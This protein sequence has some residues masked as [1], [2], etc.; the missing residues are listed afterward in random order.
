MYSYTS[1]GL[2]TKKRVQ[3]DGHNLDGTYTYN[4]EGRVATVQHP[5]AQND[6]GLTWTYSFDSMGRPYSLVDN[7][8][9]PYHMVTSA[10]YGPS[11]EELQINGLA[12]RTYNSLL[13]LTSDGTRGYIYSAT[14]NNGRIVQTTDPQMGTVTYGYDSLNRLASASSSAG[15][16][17]TFTYDGFGNLTDKTVTSGAAPA[18]PVTMDAAVNNRISNTSGYGYDTT[19]NLTAGPGFLYATYDVQNRMATWVPTSGG[20]EY[21]SYGPDNM[22]VWKKPPS[23]P[24]EVYFYGARGEK[25]GRFSYG[26]GVFATLRRTVYFVRLNEGQDRLD[27]TRNQGG[28]Y[29]YGEAQTAGNN[30]QDRFATYYRDGTSLLDY[31]RNRYYSSTLGRFMSADPYRASKG[32]VNNPVNPGS[33]NR[34]AYVTG[35]PVNFN[36]PNGTYAGDPGVGCSVSIDGIVYPCNSNDDNSCLINE[37]DPTPNPVCDQRP[38]HTPPP[39]GPPPGRQHECSIGLWKRP[40]P[41][42][43]IARGWGNHTHIYITGTDYPGDFANLPGVMIEAGPV[44]G[45]LTG[46]INPPGQG[47]AS[48]KWN[49]SNPFKLS[50][51]EVGVPYTGPDACDDVVKLLNAV[52]GYNSGVKVPYAFLGTT[53]SNAFTFTLLSDVGLSSFFGHPSGYTPGWGQLI[54]GLTVP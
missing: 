2:I 31:A 41:S 12:S 34:Y 18:L 51:K 48:G 21:Y 1:G 47:L 24:E 52:N 20:T 46:L 9:T 42:G 49:A 39:S 33:W 29:P 3:V 10:T 32:S 27:S 44:N 40:T 4:S 19:G 53:N 16:G 6:P 13:Q 25:L 5:S 37:F 22:R 43:T 38:V 15:W 45:Q 17:E 36:D 54:P 30:D 11:D 7:E 28:Y 23:G 50:N 35:D 26:T 14:Q 8:P